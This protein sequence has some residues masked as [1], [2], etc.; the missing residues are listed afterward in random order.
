MPEQN[1]M[2]V[3]PV[4]SPV[5]STVPVAPVQAQKS[6]LHSHRLVYFILAIIIVLA[7]G[8]GLLIKIENFKT[9]EDINASTAPQA[10]DPCANGGAHTALE[11]SRLRN[12]MATSTSD[13]TA[14]STVDS[15]EDD[16]V[17]NMASST[18]SSTMDSAPTSSPAQN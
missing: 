17:E 9:E 2:P 8:A 7:A 18:A 12:K 1:Q 16:S 14:S 11:C 15:I 5:S 10:T 3:S 6:A 13:S 4:Q